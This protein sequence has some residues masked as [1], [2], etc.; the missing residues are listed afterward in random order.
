MFKANKNNSRISNIFKSKGIFLGLHHFTTVAN[1]ERIIKAGMLYPRVYLGK[2]KLNFNNVSSN[3]PSSVHCVEF[4][5]VY[6]HLLMSDEVDDKF[7]LA[8][9]HLIFSKVLLKQRNY[10]V[11]FVDQ[12]G[13]I[14]ENTVVKSRLMDVD[15]LESLQADSEI[16]FHDP[17]SLKALQ[18]IYVTNKTSY[19]DL[20]NRLKKLKGGFEKLLILGDTIPDKN[21]N[22]YCDLP[23]IVTN[24]RGITNTTLRPNFVACIPEDVPREFWRKYIDNADTG[25]YRKANI[26]TESRGRFNFFIRPIQEFYAFNPK[27]RPIKYKWI[28]GVNLFS[29]NKNNNSNLKQNLINKINKDPLFPMKDMT[30]KMIKGFKPGQTQKFINTL[31]ANQKK[32]LGL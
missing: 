19:D 21:F 23:V 16:V 22:K 5:G 28:P 32:R 30:I 4:P 13:M 18:A 7:R 12:N 20:Y 8:D 15:V 24:A 27:S 14:N 31:N 11:N 26:Q 3:G 17:I 25:I 2:K 9:V 10:H 6:L 29:N 1:C